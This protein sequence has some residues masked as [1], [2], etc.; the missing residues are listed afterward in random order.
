LFF[1]SAIIHKGERYEKGTVR[2]TSH[3][4]REMAKDHLNEADIER[5]LRGAVEPAEYENGQWRYRFHSQQIWAVVT[6]RDG[7]IIVIVTAW[8]ASR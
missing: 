3:A 7:Q 8:R 2:Y 6:F 4:L 5:A 1:L